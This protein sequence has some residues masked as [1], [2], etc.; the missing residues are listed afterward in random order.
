MTDIRKILKEKLGKYGA[1]EY[2]CSPQELKGDWEK[3]VYVTE[4]KPKK[5]ED[6]WLRSKLLPVGRIVEEDQ[7]AHTWT[8]VFDVGKW[9]A[10]EAFAVLAAEEDMLYVAVFAKDKLFTKGTAEKAAGELL[11]RF[12]R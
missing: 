8:I 6:L 9:R 7:E 4:I 12:G 3:N 1:E 5:T 10:S 11:K 2:I